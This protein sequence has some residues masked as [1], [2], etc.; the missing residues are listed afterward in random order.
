MTLYALANAH[1]VAVGVLAITLISSRPHLQRWGFVLG[2]YNQWAWWY[3]AWHDGA[4][5][6]AIANAAYAINYV[7]AIRTY[8][9]RPSCSISEGTRSERVT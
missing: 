7:R 2:L 4:W 9:W 3:V 5:G 1:L 8:F 6:V